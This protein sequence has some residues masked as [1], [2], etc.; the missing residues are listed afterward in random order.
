MT[1]DQGTTHKLKP[2]SFIKVIFCSNVF[3]LSTRACFLGSLS[4]LSTIYSL[5]QYNT[6]VLE[7]N[8]IYNSFPLFPIFSVFDKSLYYIFFS[9]LSKKNPC[10]QFLWVQTLLP[11]T[12][13]IWSYLHQLFDN[14]H[15]IKGYRKL[16]KRPFD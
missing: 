12:N 4:L 6:S 15:S 7:C 9:C 8:S 10:P 2:R 16:S 14:S 3:I 5:K 1:R 13:F 11:V